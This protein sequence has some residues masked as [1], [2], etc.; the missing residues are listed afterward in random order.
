MKELL[1]LLRSRPFLTAELLTASFF[2]NV[3]SLVSPL[4]FIL[5]FNK[6]VTSGFDGTLITL[7]AGMLLA[8]ALKAAFGAARNRL[9][10]DVTGD[11]EPARLHQI[12]QI[13]L[14][15]KPAN[16][17]G[18][19]RSQ[20]MDAVQAPQA[21]MSAYSPQNIGAILDAPFAILSVIVIFLLNSTLGLAT[22]AAL[23]ISAV[24]NLLGTHRLRGPVREAA[25]ASAAGRSVVAQALL[26]PDAVRVF[27]WQNHLLGAWNTQ[28][29]QMQAQRRSAFRAE[30]GAQSGLEVVSL[31]TRTVIIAVGARLVV[32]GELSVG[33]LIGASYLAG[34]P[35][36]IFSRFLRASATLRAVREQMGG[37]RDIASLPTESEQGLAIGNLSGKVQ[38][39]DLAFGWPGA[40]GPLFESVSLA[41]DQGGFLA[42]TGR[43]GTGKTSMA[44]L[45]AGLLDPVRGQILIDGQDLR[46]L[47]PAWWRRQI[48]YL[49]QEPVFMN[50]TVFENIHIVRPG[51]SP[52]DVQ[53]VVVQA[54]LK[55]F[56]NSQPRGLETMVEEGGRLLSPGIRRRLALARALAVDGQVAIFDEPTEA[57]DAE[58]CKTVLDVI[59]ELCAR[60]KT[61]V[62][63]TNDMRILPMAG[64]YLDLNVK[65]EPRITFPGRRPSHD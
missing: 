26:E 32:H 41:L 29:R 45:L 25:A 12:F 14:R 60:K 40:T 9:S 61:I 23:C 34:M 7:T 64:A 3:L 63:C 17:I 28:M 44:R 16:L 50:A 36:A 11:R 58:G 19:S 27:G 10:E 42:V 33:A 46:Q 62:V 20:V 22:L 54:G 13:L 57:L 30:G 37:A 49:P 6:Y 8:V 59:R 43:N 56:L 24:I 38:F 48:M 55:P 35:V 65:P 21:C 4:F 47:A 31:L 5:V 2:I 51:M 53:K 15:A 18:L 39:S 1:F 52:E